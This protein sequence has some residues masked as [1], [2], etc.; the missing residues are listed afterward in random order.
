MIYSEYQLEQLINKYTRIAVTT[1]ERNEQ[2]TTKSL[3]GHF[4]TTK[5]GNILIADI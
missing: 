5:P 1:N 4:S 3:I 2:K